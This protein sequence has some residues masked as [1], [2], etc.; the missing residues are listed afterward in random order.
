MTDSH[1]YPDREHAKVADWLEDQARIATNSLHCGDNS[2]TIQRT[3]AWARKLEAA[4]LHLRSVAQG[5]LPPLLDRGELVRLLQDLASVN[6]SMEAC[7]RQ[8]N[9][10]ADDLIARGLTFT[11]T[12]RAILPGHD[13]T[14]A[15]LDALT[16][17]STDPRCTCAAIVNP[18][19]PHARTCPLFSPESQP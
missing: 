14:M 17:K 10:I 7:E 8:A 3:H 4:A 5:S 15:N 11:S 19:I 6:L 1:S 13:E 18:N 12:A 16:I 2:G 9:R